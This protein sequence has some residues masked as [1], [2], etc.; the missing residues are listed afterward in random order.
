MLSIKRVLP[1]LAATNTTKFISL[2]E[3]WFRVADERIEM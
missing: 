3:A 2:I 1:I